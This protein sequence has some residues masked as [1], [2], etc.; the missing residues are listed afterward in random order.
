MECAINYGLHRGGDVIQ[1]FKHI[2]RLQRTWVSTSFAC[3]AKCL[4]PK[5]PGQSL[6]CQFC[7][8]PGGLRFNH[9]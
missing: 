8:N 6:Q 5:L 1:F 7:Y 2:Q 3:R 9:K 4:G